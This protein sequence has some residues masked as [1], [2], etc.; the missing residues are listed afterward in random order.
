[1]TASESSRIDR[2]FNQLNQGFD[3]ANAYDPPYKPNARKIFDLRYP[4][5]DEFGSPTEDPKQVHWR[6]DLNVASVAV[7]YQPG[8]VWEEGDAEPDVIDGAPFG[9]GGRL[10]LAQHHQN[11]RKLHDRAPRH[12]DGRTQ[13]HTRASVRAQDAAHGSG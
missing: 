6:I 2:L 13:A 3:V 1:M 10:L 9:T 7:L 11:V 8:A 5:K 4:R 12:R